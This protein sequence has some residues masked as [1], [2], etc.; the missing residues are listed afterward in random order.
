LVITP[1]GVNHSIAGLAVTGNVFRMFGAT[2]DRV[3]RVDTSFASFNQASYRNVVFSNNSF[4]G[5]TQST[6]SPVMIEHSQNT[7]STTWVVGA[8]GFLPFGGRARNVTGIVAEGAITNSS[9]AAQ[10]VMPYVL[11]KQSTNGQSVHIKWP[12]AVKG[13]AQVTIRFDNPL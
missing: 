1:R 11:T 10:Y 9:G 8:A 6:A 2:I 5:V 7:E 12:N 3:E 13:R 4:N